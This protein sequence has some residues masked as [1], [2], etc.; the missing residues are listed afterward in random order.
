MSKNGFYYKDGNN[1]WYHNK[2]GVKETTNRIDL[3]IDNDTPVIH[4]NAYPSA[5]TTNETPT[6]FRNLNDGAEF[7]IISKY[8]GKKRSKKSQKRG[9]KSRKRSKKAR[10]S[11]RKHFRK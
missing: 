3:D 4:T 2:D 9:K 11:R 8:G 6:T 7:K 1:V 10:R 5:S